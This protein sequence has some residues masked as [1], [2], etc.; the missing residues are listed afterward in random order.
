MKSK[1][2]IL[3]ILVV[4]IAIANGSCILPVIPTATL[5]FEESSLSPSPSPTE[6]SPRIPSPTKTNAPTR[7]PHHRDT[8][9]PTPD[10]ALP[11]GEATNRLLAN[12]ANN[13]GCRFPCL[14]E[15]T[16]GNTSYADAWNIFEAFNNISTFTE[17][18]RSRFTL[19]PQYIQGDLL[20]DMHLF[21]LSKNNIISNISFHA[22]ANKIIM[23][24]G[25]RNLMP[26]YGYAL[27]KELLKYYLLNHLLSEYG[28][29]ASVL[30]YTE[31]IVGDSIHSAPLDL[32]LLYPDQGIVAHYNTNSTYSGGNIVGCPA[33]A[34]VDFDL[35]PPSNESA[36]M[37]LITPNWKDY[38]AI[39][40][41]LEDVTSMSVEQFYQAFLQSANACITTPASNWPSQ[42]QGG[43]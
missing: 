21:F 40:K 34:I 14:W 29:P 36:F 2:R 25:Q 35:Y 5:G 19:D 39:S 28:S 31:V 12:L 18:D 6:P 4:V 17:F 41:P 16:P 24:N 23:I 43:Q 33:N 26:V 37:D 13:G 1:R 42:N 10:V 8:E 7:T 30:L 32:L 20:I 3:P 27:F 22:S 15:I 9:T 38:L 11:A